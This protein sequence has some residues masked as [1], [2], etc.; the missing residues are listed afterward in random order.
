MSEE[1]GDEIGSEDGRMTS[2]A[3]LILVLLTLEGREY[4]PMTL[5]EIAEATGLPAA[6]ALAKLKCL[7]VNGLAEK[8]NGAY[9]LGPRIISLAHNFYTGAQ[10]HLR[11]MQEDFLHLTGGKTSGEQR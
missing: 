3:K 6:T 5:G 8:A 4:A 1:N 7:E 10:E 2:D 11:R 9:R